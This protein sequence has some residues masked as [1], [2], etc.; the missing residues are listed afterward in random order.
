M[1]LIPLVSRHKLFSH[2]IPMDEQKRLQFPPPFSSI[3]C[4]DY[5]TAI[6]SQINKHDPSHRRQSSFAWPYKDSGHSFANPR[7]TME[8]KVHDHTKF[9]SNI[10]T[11]CRS[12]MSVSAQ[13][14]D[15]FDVKQEMVGESEKR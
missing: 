15:V 3:E 13:S 2:I 5:A 14:N 1:A 12:I 4:K 8:A 10:S 11:A 6:V 9:S 7:Q